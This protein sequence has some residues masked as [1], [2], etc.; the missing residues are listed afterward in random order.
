[1]KNEFSETRSRIERMFEDAII[2]VSKITT[3]SD[4][5]ICS[6]Y[7]EPLILEIKKMLDGAERSY[8]NDTPYIVRGDKKNED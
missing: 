5:V 7:P 2:E 1:M 4:L 3:P 8:L 6:P